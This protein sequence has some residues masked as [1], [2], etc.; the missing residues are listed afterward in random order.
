MDDAEREARHPIRVVAERTGLSQEVLRVWERRYDAV[1]PTRSEGGQRLYTD[2]D[3]NRLRLLRRVTHA[4]RS[5]GSVARLPLAELTRLVREDNEARANRTRAVE[6][7]VGEPDLEAAVEYTR[8]LDRA[9]LDALLTRFATVMGAPQF[10]QQVAAPFMRRVGDEWHAGQLRPAHEHLAT[11]VVQQ[12]V[13][14]VLGT[15]GDDGDA[16]A[17]VVA[18]LAGERHEVGAL[19]AAATAAA[20]GWRVVYLGA[21][22]PADEIAAAAVAT[23]ARAVGVSVIFVED[24]ERLAAEL[25]TLRAALPESVPLLVGGAGAAALGRTDSDAGTIRIIEL[26]ALRDALRRWR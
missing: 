12:V 25:Q 18:S 26:D 7:S 9:G 22:L 24:A 11:A 3:V 23:G 13:L 20:E 17:F 1:R 14:R 5:I 8:A 19:L 15:L 21:D 16:P 6:P 10:L 4:G 2:E